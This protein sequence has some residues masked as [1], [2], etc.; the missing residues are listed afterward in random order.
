MDNLMNDTQDVK[1]VDRLI[2]R[3]ATQTSPSLCMLIEQLPLIFRVVE[4]DSQETANGKHEIVA[5]IFHENASLRVKWLADTYDARLKKGCLV[6]IRW[7]GQT[8]CELGAI[9]ISR[10]VLVDQPPSGLNIFETVP[11]DWVKD[12]SLIQR[13]ISVQSKMP[14]RYQK[15]INGI[16]WEDKRFWQF[17]NY[18]SSLQHHHAIAHGNFIHTLEVCE[19]A[20]KVAL[21]KNVNVPLLILIGFLHDIGKAGEYWYHEQHQRFYLSKRGQLLGHKLTAIEWAGEAKNKFQIEFSDHEWLAILHGFS[22]TQGI[23]DWTGFRQPKTTEA[24][25]LSMID[26]LSVRQ[27]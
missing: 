24:S 19:L 27:A 18:P 5:E 17:L 15:L 22:A 8:V 23:A 16:L 6:S 2:M 14:H 25:L 13:A 10:L 26:N 12:R 7:K 11:I 20:Q 21:N 4:I 9:I 3:L 1:V